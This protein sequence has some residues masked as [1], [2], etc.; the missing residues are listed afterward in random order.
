M[1]DMSSLYIHSNYSTVLNSFNVQKAST[2]CDCLDWILFN[3]LHLEVSKGKCPICEYTFSENF[4]RP[5]NNGTTTIKPT[6]DHYRPINLYPLLKC[7]DKNYLLMCSEC[8]T[9]Y[10]DNLFPLHASTPDRDT[11]SMSISNSIIEKP[12]IVNPIFDNLSDLFTLIFVTNQNGK[13]ILALKPK[14]NEGYLYEKAKKTIEIFGLGN[15]STSIHPNQNIHNCRITVL[16][17]N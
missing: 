4:T 17:Y 15:C 5:S 14:N 8:N 11:I 7:D 1:I 16:E 13:K 12:L 10:K 9:S 6:I 2:D 3:E